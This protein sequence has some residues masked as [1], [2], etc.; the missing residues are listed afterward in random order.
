MPPKWII[1]WSYAAQMHRHA[2]DLCVMRWR[3]RKFPAYDRRCLHPSC[4]IVSYIER[5]RVRK[6]RVRACRCDVC[7]KLW[8]AELDRNRL[9]VVEVVA[10]GVASDSVYMSAR[11]CESEI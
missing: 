8:C 11:A 10:G 2:L 4:A 1:G 5:S 7:V 3:I 6:D 9:T